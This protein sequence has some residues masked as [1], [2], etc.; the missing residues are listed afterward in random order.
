M[1]MNDLLSQ[2]EVDALLAGLESGDLETEGPSVRNEGVPYDL[3]NSDNPLSGTPRALSRI[4]EGFVTSFRKQL[5]ELLNHPVDLVFEGIDRIEFS[6]YLEDKRFPQSFNI[7]SASS[8]NGWGI[9][10][11][12]AELISIMV[13]VFFAMFIE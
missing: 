11:L 13:D 5:S 2:D 1:P 12:S 9:I 6:E 10:F 4:Y 8:L 7:V 3:E